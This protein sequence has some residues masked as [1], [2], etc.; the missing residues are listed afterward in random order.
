MAST[1]AAPAADKSPAALYGA[2]SAPVCPL[3]RVEKATGYNCQESQDCQTQYEEKCSTEYLSECNTV[4]D[5]KCESKYK[6]CNLICYIH[7]LFVSKHDYE[8]ACY[9]ISTLNLTSIRKKNEP[10]LWA[11]WGL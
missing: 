7:T 9:D 8:R 4:Y 10:S 3:T 2:P 6:K 11:P 1:Y 5:T